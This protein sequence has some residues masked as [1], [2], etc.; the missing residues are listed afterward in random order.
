[1][2]TTN[3]ATKTEVKCLCCGRMVQV[4]DGWTARHL[5]N[6]TNLG[7]GLVKKMC[8]GSGKTA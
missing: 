8:K 2:T 7:G 1:M 3:A 5:V 6:R 4:T